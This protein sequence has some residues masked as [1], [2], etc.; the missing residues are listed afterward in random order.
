MTDNRWFVRSILT[1]GLVLLG[2]IPAVANAQVATTVSGQVKTS[3]GGTPLY[4]V[5][6]SIPSLRVSAAT[7]AQGRYQLVIPAGTS[8]PVTLSAR[9]IGFKTQS[10]QI[11]P[12][13]ASVQQDI[14]LEEGAIELES[15]IVTALGIERAP[16]SLSY[17]TQSLNG[18]QLSA[19]PTQNV[20]SALQ[21]NVAGVQ[22]TN[23]ANPFGSA[24][25]VVRGA[26]SNSG[27]GSGEFGGYD[28]GNAAADLSADN[29]ASVTVLK[30][31]NAAALY[32]SRAANGAIVYTTKS[33]KGAPQGGY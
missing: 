9:L 2:L 10:V 15:K 3:V 8:G 23:S 4:G 14:A 22:V 18:D 24:R 16:R 28:V 30:G 32:G 11:T 26:V 5:I 13:G 17:A 29:I 25:I 21:G 12:S 33:G 19:V 31:P 6:V 1:I 7:D 27:Y 20:V